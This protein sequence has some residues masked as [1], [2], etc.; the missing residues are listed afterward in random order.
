[1]K[2]KDKSKWIPRCTFFLSLSHHRTPFPLDRNRLLIIPV[3][4]ST[5]KQANISSLF[6]THILS[7]SCFAHSAVHRHRSLIPA[8]STESL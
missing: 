5:S 1:M 8:I 3:Y 7:L 6:L 2:K 4:Y